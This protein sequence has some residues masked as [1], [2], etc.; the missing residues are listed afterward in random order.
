MC[1]CMTTLLERQAFI[2]ELKQKPIYSDK[3]NI[4]SAWKWGCPSEPATFFGDC[5][6]KVLSHPTWTSAAEAFGY[7]HERSTPSQRAAKIPEGQEA[8]KPTGGV[9]YVTAVVETSPQ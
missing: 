8:T 3:T 7:K 4:M 1:D 9:Q 2:D 6:W 5:G